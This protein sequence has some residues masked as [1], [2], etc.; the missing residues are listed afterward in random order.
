MRADT[1]APSGA[2][3]IDF[4]GFRARRGAAQAAPIE[5]PANL[6]TDLRLGDHILCHETQEIGTVTAVK[7]SARPGGRTEITI[8][9]ASRR[10]R[11][12]A[13]EIEGWRD[14][15]AAAALDGARCAAA[16]DLPAGAATVAEL[17]PA[18]LALFT[19]PAAQPEQA[20]T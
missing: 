6:P 7:P 17:S 1:S 12:F 10:R 14:H 16:A 5:A 15:G 9:F 20:R 13:D 11:C 19:F 18:Q 4:A 8:Q 3:I 2:T